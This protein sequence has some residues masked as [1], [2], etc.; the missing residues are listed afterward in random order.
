MYIA[1][2]CWV[3]DQTLAEIKKKVVVRECK[4]FPGKVKETM[5]FFGNT[6]HI[7][8]TSYKRPEIKLPNLWSFLFIHFARVNSD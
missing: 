5:I 2:Y 7:D 8:K 6:N 1:E 4:F 3:K